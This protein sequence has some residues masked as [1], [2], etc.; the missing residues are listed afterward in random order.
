MLVTIHF[1][2][3]LQPM[4]GVKSHRFDISALSEIK[5]ALSVLFPKIR[6]YIRQITMG[7]LRENLSLITSEGKILTRK[8][9]YLDMK[10]LHYNL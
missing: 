4:T 6:R 3:L 10:V 8:E 5:N 2:P 7:T 1:H 9:Y